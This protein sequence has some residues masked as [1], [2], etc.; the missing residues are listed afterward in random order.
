MWWRRNSGI[1]AGS[2][3]ERCKCSNRKD[4]TAGKMAEET[5][6]DSLIILTSVEKVKINMDRPEGRRTERER[7]VLIRQKPI[8]KKDISEN[9]TC[10]RSSEQL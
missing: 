2:P 4:L 8:W 10:I 7:S 6:A 3:S 9:I 1:R 5:D